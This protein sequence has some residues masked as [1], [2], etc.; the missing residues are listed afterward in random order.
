MFNGLRFLL[1][2]IIHAIKKC[3]LYHWERVV[4]NEVG[5][6]FACVAREMQWP[7]EK[8]REMKKSAEKCRSCGCPPK[9]GNKSNGR[10]HIC[11]RS[12]WSNK[13]KTWKDEHFN[14]VSNDADQGLWLVSIQLWKLLKLQKMPSIE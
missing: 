12:R 14:D 13:T 4:G 8:C 6:V 1:P 5:S 11:I 3:M 2:D 9:R 7:E 10:V